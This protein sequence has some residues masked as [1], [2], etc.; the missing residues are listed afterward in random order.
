VHKLVVKLINSSIN[1]KLNN[2]LIKNPI[3]NIKIKVIHAIKSNIK[4]N[5]IK[6]MS[7]HHNIKS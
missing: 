1:I 2:I 7:N 5:N 6:S 3:I 4:S